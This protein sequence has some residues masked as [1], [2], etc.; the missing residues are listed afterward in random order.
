[1]N[2]SNIDQSIEK[3]RMLLAREKHISPALKA[4]IEVLCV[5]LTAL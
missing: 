1:M 5:A 4:T 2:R 3:A